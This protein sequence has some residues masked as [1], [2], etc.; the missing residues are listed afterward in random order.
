[1]IGF[2]VRIII[3]FAGER[4]FE[5]RECG[6]AFST[7]GNMHRHMRIHKKYGMF[8]EERFLKDGVVYKPRGKKKKLMPSR[9]SNKKFPQNSDEAS[10]PKRRRLFLNE[11]DQFGNNSMPSRPELHRTTTT[12]FQRQVLNISTVRVSLQ[13]YSISGNHGSVLGPFLFSLYISP[14]GQ[15]VSDFGLAHQQY[16][17][18]SQL[19]ISLKGDNVTDSIT[20]LEACLD[21]LRTWLCHNGLCLNPDKSES[22]LFGTRQR[23]RTFP[24]IPSINIAGNDIKLSVQITSLGVIM[25]STLTFD[26]HVTA[27]CKACHFHLKSLRHIRRSLSTDMAIFDCCCNGAIAARLLQLPALWH[28]SFQ[29]QQTSAGPESRS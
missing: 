27:L 13:L 22:I 9:P 7:N 25:D 20:R 16:A 29:Y 28:L 8:S 26:A 14:I 1:M 6:M 24:V 18:D 19:Y 21:N 5:C 3:L 17:D 23:L 12:L 10:E 15:I 4:P 11:M 2:H